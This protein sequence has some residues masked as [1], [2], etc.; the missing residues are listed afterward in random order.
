MAVARSDSNIGFRECPSEGRRLEIR[1]IAEAACPAR[2]L[3]YPPLDSAAAAFLADGVLE[4]GDRDV[5][6][7]IRERRTTAG[8]RLTHSGDELGVV[9]RIQLLG[10]EVQAPRPSLAKDA[11]LSPE[12]I[13]AKPGIVSK[14]RQ[15]AGRVEEVSRLSESI[16]LKRLV[17]LDV[18]FRRIL[19][20]AQRFW[21]GHLE[22]KLGEYFM[23]LSQLSRTTSGKQ[24]NL[25][26]H[27]RAHRAAQRRA[28]EFHSMRARVADLV[29]GDRKCRVR[30]FPAPRQTFPRCSL[31]RSCRPRLSHL[32]RNRDRGEP[33]RRSPRR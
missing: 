8:P 1:I 30:P 23:E 16:F 13:Y 6:R 26:A 12:C 2:R 3:E 19:G 24:E 9:R 10:R 17:A 5:P 32:P 7:G 31:R 20:N 14:R 33:R 27:S 28:R 29:V 15:P 22:A 11:G 25:T 4:R 18:V 21:I